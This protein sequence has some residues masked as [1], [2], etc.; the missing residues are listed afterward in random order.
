MKA[1]GM[2]T[3]ALVFVIALAASACA[4]PAPTP[5]PVP[6]TPTPAPTLTPPPTPTPTPVPTPTPA[7]TPTKAPLTSGEIRDLKFEVVDGVLQISFAFSGESSDYN[8]FHVFVDAD[9]SPKTGYLISGAGADFL[10]ENAGLFSYKGGGSDWNWEPVSA[11]DMAF[12]MGKNTVLWKVKL[13]DLKLDKA[14]AADF[15]AQLVNINWDAVATTQKVTKELK[16]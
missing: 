11:P 13:A 3:T 16:R 4:A 12:E 5:T 7:V 8:A 1:K 9:Q 10:M 14:K 2:F 6:P 15:V